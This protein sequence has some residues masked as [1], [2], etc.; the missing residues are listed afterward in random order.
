MLSR[1]AT[2]NETP[3]VPLQTAIAKLSKVG[4]VLPPATEIASVSL[5]SAGLTL[6]A[7]TYQP[8]EFELALR[9]AF[10]SEQISLTMEQETEGRFV[11]TVSVR[12]RVEGERRS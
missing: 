7:R 2:P 1:R 8:D 5:A 3:A 12:P 4:E 10:E 9:R 6:S 11:L